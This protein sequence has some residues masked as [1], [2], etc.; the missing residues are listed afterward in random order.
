MGLLRRGQPPPSVGRRGG[1][2]PV[3]EEAQSQG[4]GALK[5]WPFGDRGRGNGVNG[6]GDESRVTEAQGGFRG[7]AAECGSPTSTG[8][9]PVLGGS[10]GQSVQYAGVARSA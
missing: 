9:D 2:V 5:A 1:G 4:T 8:A 10:G 3:M 7:R 6:T